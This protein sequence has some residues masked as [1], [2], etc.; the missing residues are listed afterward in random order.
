MIDKAGVRP[1]L[2]L[3]FNKLIIKH[4]KNMF[5]IIKKSVVMIKDVL[6]MKILIES[7]TTNYDLILIIIKQIQ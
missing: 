1:N 3:S 2:V 4:L 6:T 5:S 7:L